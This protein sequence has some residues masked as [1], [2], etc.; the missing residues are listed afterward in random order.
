[1]STELSAVTSRNGKMSTD[2]TLESV[3]E[4]S[5]KSEKAKNKA[6]SVFVKADKNNDGQLDAYEIKAYDRKQAWKTAGIVA[7]TLV[8]GLLV[9]K[10]G[11]G[12]IK[13]ANTGRYDKL[14]KKYTELVESK[15]GDL[16]HAEGF[17]QQDLLSGMMPKFNTLT[18]KKIN[19]PRSFI[20]N[21]DDYQQLMK[22]YAKLVG[23]KST[24]P[25]DMAKFL[26]ADLK[27][28]EM[29]LYNCYTGAKINPSESFV[30]LFNAFK[31]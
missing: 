23:G 12:I 8:A 31:R 15:S 11:I 10:T 18:G 17:M 19:H 20:R 24:N 22:E 2:M 3:R 25:A 21:W 14:L 29:P 4:G 9:A 27:S 30:K 28:G 16:T 7:G 26:Q 6:I 13:K 1:M 5:Y